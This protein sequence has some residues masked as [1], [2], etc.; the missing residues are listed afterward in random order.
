MR[1][2][3]QHHP[4]QHHVQQHSMSQS[5]HIGSH[6]RVKPHQNEITLSGAFWDWLTSVLCFQR[7]L[8]MDAHAILL[9]FIFINEAGFNLAKTRRRGGNVHRS[10]TFLANMVETSQSLPSPIQA[11]STTVMPAL[12]HTTSV[13]APYS[14]KYYITHYTLLSKI[15]MPYITHT[16]IHKT[17]M[18]S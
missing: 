1:N 6:S 16:Y 2:S 10:I 4:R 18:K 14:K 17:H 8:E 12:D 15:L 3:K 13:G 5:V 9:E 11:V 7:V